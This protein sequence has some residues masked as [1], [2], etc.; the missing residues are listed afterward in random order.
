MKTP[1]LVALGISGGA[2]P[3]AYKALAAL[4]EAGRGDEAREVLASVVADPGGCIG[5]EHVG[6]LAAALIASKAEARPRTEPA[7]WRSWTGPDVEPTAV[8]QMVNAC[9]IPV[10]VQGAL[11]P[12]AHQG[13]GLPIG[14]VLATDNAVVPFAVG[15]DIACRMKLSVLDVPGFGAFRDRLLSA[16]ETETR[17]GVGAEFK[18][19][20]EH[21]VMDEDWRVTPVTAGQKDKAWRQLGTSGSGNHF[22]EF[23][24]LDLDAP[25][26]DVPAGRYVALLTHSGSRGAGATVAAHFS[27]LAEQMHPE[28]PAALRKLAWLGL[29]TEEG[30]AYWRAMELMGRYAAANHD[31]IHHHIARALG[32]AIL[33]GVE[34]HHNFAWRETHGGRE[35]IVHRKGATPAGAGVLGVIPGTMADPAFIVA[36]KGS[37]ESLESASH[38]AGRRMSRT[39]ARRRFNW[40]DARQLLADR[41]VELVSGD[42]DEV[43]MAYKDIREVMALQT[44]LVQVL[45]TFHP[46]LVKMAPAGERP[47]D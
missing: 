30:Q 26:G 25:L 18:T 7:P 32:A 27:K 3:A 44:D 34:N 42:L 40:T 20:R 17:F 1:D 46:R 19:P 2:L 36:G 14:G 37:A 39:E 9:M 41:S 13:Y 22:A 11:M 38:G 5:L 16:L 35:V 6:D 12:D 24:D 47:E 10:A 43:P 28:L 45:G 21:P 33:G 8:Q 15:V 31:R 29:D 4:A 23:G